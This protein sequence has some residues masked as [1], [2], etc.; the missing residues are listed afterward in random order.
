MKSKKLL[1]SIAIVAVLIV[2]IVVMAAVLSVEQV[3]ATYH[4]FDGSL[5]ATPADGVAKDD[6]QS[7]AK[8][9]S[10]V[11]LSKSKLIN[12][13]NEAYP[14]WHA[15]AVVKNFPNI[16]EIHLVRRTAVMKIEVSGA[17]VYVDSF[18]CVTKVP[19]EG[20]VIDV[21]SAFE[22]RDATNAK[23][24]EVFEFQLDENNARLQYILQAILAT[25]QCNVEI[26]DMP[27]ILGAENI[28]AFDDD[29]NML[30]SPRAGG[31]IKIISPEV[32]LSKRLINAYGVYYNEKIDL[33]NG[34]ITVQENGSISSSSK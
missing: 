20:N 29:G 13:F 10:I 3:V 1:V 34:V 30:I 17:F 14:E 24:G 28:F 32:D 12:Q 25:W 11:F 26:E 7:L 4:A 8:G 16:V 27:E 9:K 33:T 31:T 5:M 2:V 21:S 22:S 19:S 18:G 15:F 6:I 23:V